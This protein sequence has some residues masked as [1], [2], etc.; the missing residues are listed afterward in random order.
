M[1]APSVVV[2]AHPAAV[3]SGLA[4]PATVSVAVPRAQLPLVQITTA[5]G[6][7]YVPPPPRPAR[8]VAQLESEQAQLAAKG[9]RPRGSFFTYNF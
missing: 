7:A 3:T 9:A 8:S 1:P 2:A 6:A 4:Q 5:T